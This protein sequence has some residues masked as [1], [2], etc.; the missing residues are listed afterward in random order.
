MVR[1]RRGSGV[2][3]L[4]S[5]MA[6]APQAVV[7]AD[8]G[9]LDR[10]EGNAVRARTLRPTAPRPT[11]RKKSKRPLRGAVCLW[12]TGG[13]IRVRGWQG[14]S[15]AR[16]R[17]APRAPD[18]RPPA[19]YACSVSRVPLVPS[20]G[21]LV[22]TRP[23][24]PPAARAPERWRSPAAGSGQVQCLVRC[25]SPARPKVFSVSRQITPPIASVPG[26]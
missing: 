20:T 4:S 11:R 8:M 17:A 12:T 2:S 19:L 18:G 9:R 21:G 10:R 26:A 23:H 7:G 3:A 1:G 14:L 6:S 22:G 5:A 15:P 25:A 24:P 13:L 16:P